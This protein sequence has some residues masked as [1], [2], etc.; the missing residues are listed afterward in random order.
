[1][2]RSGGD[3]AQRRVGGRGHSEGW[4]WRQAKARAWNG[5]ARARA[6]EQRWVRAWRRRVRAAAAARESESERVRKKGFT[7]GK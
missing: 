1:V 5:W 6:K 3:G 7:V 4:A 2:A